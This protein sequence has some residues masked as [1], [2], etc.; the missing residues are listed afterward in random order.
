MSTLRIVDIIDVN[1]KTREEK[2]DEAVDR[3]SLLHDLREH[4][5]KI[6]ELKRKLDR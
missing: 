1:G 6:N 4:L 5:R 3:A 2:I